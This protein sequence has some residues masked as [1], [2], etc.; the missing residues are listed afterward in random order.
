M[1]RAVAIITQALRPPVKRSVGLNCGLGAREP[2]RLV[3]VDRIAGAD[4]AVARG[5]AHVSAGKSDLV[6]ELALYGYVVLINHRHGENIGPELR[7][8]PVGKR[9][10]SVGAHRD[11]SRSNRPSP[12]IE[13]GGERLRR[14]VVD[15]LVVQHRRVLGHVVTEGGTERSQIVRPA[16]AGTNH[17]LLIH[18]ISQAK[19]WREFVPIHLL[20]AV[21]GNPAHPENVHQ[22][23]L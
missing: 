12:Q 9:E 5:I 13:Y 14:R 19:P 20:D 22:A 15:L 11:G 4:P 2:F 3:R 8:D 1:V 18:L 23:I 7:T 21:I 10:G 16:I 6:G 17:C